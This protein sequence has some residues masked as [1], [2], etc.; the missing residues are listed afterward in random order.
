MKG[1]V[2]A[3]GTGS[4]LRPMTAAMCKQLLPVFDKPMVYYPLT[5]LMLAGIREI[6]VIS[7]PG[8]RPAFERLLGDGARW[9]LRV[10]HAVQAAPR[11]I[12]E[13]LCIAEGFLD[14]G[15]SMLV[16]GDNLLF[17]QGLTPAVQAAA[18]LTRGAHV[19]G[20]PV[21]DPS[22][23]GV[24]AFDGDRVTD[25]VEK[26]AQPPSRYAV[27]GLYAYDGTAPRRAAALTPSARGEIEITE[28]NRSYLADGQLGVTRL[29]RGIAWLDM[30]TPENLLAAASFVEAIQ[31]RQGYRIGCP[32][33][34][35]WRQGWIDDVQLDALGRAL[36]G[37]DYGDYLCRLAAEGR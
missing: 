36:R 2:L 29:G 1:I 11:G 25:L 4:R 28:L 21:N 12:A 3:G 33:E 17:G 24:L 10:E 16:L 34:V 22:A 30:G 23:Y 35:A 13:A 19:F 5:V 14:G 15:P 7:T 27:P 6:L 37:T 26:P 20:Y 32:E 9:G 31:G 18:A 8:D